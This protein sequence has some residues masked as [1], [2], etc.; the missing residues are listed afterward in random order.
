MFFLWTDLGPLGSKLF[1][2][3]PQASY[4]LIDSFLGSSELIGD[5]TQCVDSAIPPEGS[6]MQVLG[7]LQKSVCP[8]ALAQPSFSALWTSPE[9]PLSILEWSFTWNAF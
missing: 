7:Q 9:H 6:L 2:F 1:P 3:P 5:L 4:C 8:M